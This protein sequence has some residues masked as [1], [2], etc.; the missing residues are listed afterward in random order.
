MEQEISDSFNHCFPLVRY[1]H[2][3]HLGRLLGNPPNDPEYMS[4]G[5]EGVLDIGVNSASTNIVP[6]WDIETGKSFV[7]VG[8]VDAAVDGRHEDFGGDDTIFMP[9]KVQGWD[10]EDDVDLQVW[11]PTQNN[12]AHS[13]HGTLMGGIIGAIRNNSTGI[14]G[15]AGG[16]WDDEGNAGVSLYSLRVLDEP[17]DTPLIDAVTA[18]RAIINGSISPDFLD[19]APFHY[20]VHILNN[21]YGF[22]PPGQSPGGPVNPLG[23]L[24]YDKLILLRDAIHVANRLHVITTAARGHDGSGI[25][26]YPACYADG[27]VLNV[28]GSN[29]SSGGWDNHCNYG[30]NIDLIAPYSSGSTT[31]TYFVPAPATSTYTG[32]G[33]SSVSTAY[34]AGAAALLLSYYNQPSFSNDNLAPEDVEF[35][36]EKAAIQPSVYDP[37]YVGAGRLNAY[38]ALNLIHK[39]EREIIHKS[40]G[41]PTG[42]ASIAVVDTG[43]L[44]KLTEP[45]TFPFWPGPY[46]AGHPALDLDTG[47]YKVDIYKYRVRVPH[48]ISVSDSLYHSW[49]VHS[50]SAL[51]DWYKTDTVSGIKV[52]QPFEK[53]TIDSITRDSAWLSGYFYKVRDAVQDTFIRWLPADT[54][55][56]PTA[57]PNLAYSMLVGQPLI[58]NVLQIGSPNFTAVLYPNP[59][60]EISYLEIKSS[61]KGPF[62]I[63]VC[64]IHGRLIILPT[65]INVNSVSIVPLDF[66]ILSRGM[67]VITIKTK[68]ASKSLRFIKS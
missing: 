36:L 47:F 28:S 11:L 9:G 39:P 61:E 4:G 7:R 17:Q 59:S 30:G 33:G 13:P 58:S 67:Y 12:L 3:N 65:V 32:V 21:S 63:S 64:D 56:M 16:D 54:S 37:Y 52:I 62:T 20:G 14:A 42:K 38:D 24:D 49:P 6:A 68:G 5:Q 46:Q 25:F 27:W 44:V 18:A 2:K 48:T 34:V 45:L 23:I 10:F 35:I 41:H 22:F 1:A 31:S 50:S 53:C 60:S 40:G 26:R 66:S 43:V 57:R 19:P 51:W 15:I 55:T 29:S 8:I